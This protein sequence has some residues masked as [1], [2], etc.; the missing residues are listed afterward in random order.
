M[1]NQESLRIAAAEICR[2]MRLSPDRADA[3]TPD[4]LAAFINGRR[5]PELELEQMFRRA[6]DYGAVD[7]EGF[8]RGPIVVRT[9]PDAGLIF[10]APAC[11]GSPGAREFSSQDVHDRFA[12]T[13]ASGRT[14]GYPFHQPIAAFLR[15]LC[16]DRPDPMERRNWGILPGP[17]TRPDTML[18]DPLP[19]EL[20][21]APGFFQ[22]KTARER[23]AALTARYPL[24]QAL[25]E[26]QA[27]HDKPSTASPAFR[28]VV[29]SAMLT[30]VALR[31]E[32]LHHFSVS[33]SEVLAWLRWD[34]EYYRPARG[35]AQLEGI[36]ERVN[37]IVLRRPG[38]GFLLPV[39][40]TAL[41]GWRRN[42]GLL[43]TTA[44]PKSAVGPRINRDVLLR[45]GAH[46][47][48]GYRAYL[49]LVCEWDYLAGR[50]GYPANPT[51]P[52]VRRNEQG[53]LLDVR[54]EVILERN[55]RPSSRYSHPRA[56]Q[57]G[58]RLPNPRACR[59]RDMDAVDL[60]DLATPDN[61]TRSHPGRKLEQAVRAL[62]SVE[63]AGGC[64]IARLDHA[65]PGGKK[66]PHKLPWKITPPDAWS[67]QSGA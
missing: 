15:R 67:G 22:P 16:I 31:D 26:A 34:P 37:R 51:I 4:A 41:A 2:A 12:N 40:V 39:S 63:Q 57:T 21:A 58:R 33:V 36:I 38:G 61:T 9:D 35:G 52:E 54:G 45:L 59:Y 43:I 14:S 6:G 49:K 44:W 8:L 32:L 20:P 62:E 27:D 66:N 18:A 11:A 29:Q 1:P 65:R 46:N 50:G 19:D 5:I 30:P 60:I 42:D 64:A 10:S 17:L 28:I 24:V 25:D 53:R 7:Y 48:F 23:T 47:P 13:P 3:V 56:V 55:G